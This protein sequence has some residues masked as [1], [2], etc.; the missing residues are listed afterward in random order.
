MSRTT[1]ALAGLIVLGAAAL[2]AWNVPQAA[3]P[4]VLLRAA[5]EKEEVDGNLDAAIEQYKQII[6][7]AGANRAVAAQALLRLGGCYEKRGPEEA[8]RAYEQLIRDYGEQSREV[9][10]A[11]QRLAALAAG[12][13]VRARDSRLAIRRVPDLDMYAKP[14]PDGKFVSSTD[15]KSGNLTIRDAATGATRALTKDGAFGEASRYPEFCAWSRDSRRIACQWTVIG[16]KEVRTELRVV[17]LDPDTPPETIAIPGVRWILPHDWSPDGSRIFCSY[18]QASSRTGFAFVRV[19]DGAIDKLDLPDGG[20]LQYELSR[21]GDAILY[22]AAADGK[23]GPHDIFLRNL[24]TGVT[25]PIIRHPA[26]D[27]LVGVLPGTDWLLFASDRQGR[28]DLWAVPFRRGK[29]DGQPVLV[30]QGLGRFFPLGFTNDGRYHYATLSA[31]DDVFLADFDPATGKVTGDARK[32]PSRWDGVSGGP[33]YSPDGASLA[34]VVKRSPMP[35]PTGVFDTL[36]VQ[37]LSDPKAGPVPIGFEDIGV[38]RV[39]DPCWSADGKAVLVRGYRAQG[40]PSALYRVDVPGLRKTMIYGANERRLIGHDCGTDGAF[41][42]AL[43]NTQASGQKAEPVTQLVRIDLTGGPDR[44]VF[45]APQGQGIGAFAVSPDGKSL[46]VVTSLDR[47]RRALLAMPSE[48]GTPRQILEFRQPTGGGVAHVWAPDGRSIFY[49][50]RSEEQTGTLSFELHSV[51][52]DGSKS[53]PDLVYK[54]TGQFFGLRFHR[55]GR[56]LAFTGRLS[57]STSSEVWV[58]ENLKEELKTL[59]PSGKRP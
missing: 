14:S 47:N 3:D 33:S 34:Y 27:L 1:L 44:L 56:T 9:A 38:T 54:W 32:L 8:R 17:S 43:L 57:Y 20:W 25:T 51:R 19:G 35:I 2:A 48:G 42:F 23:S 53:S 21:E 11:R 49:V 59:A 5:I 55:N 31:T 58:I 12:A 7:I 26:E 28:L 36:V 45:Q 52:V 29:A 10:T 22:C 46:S 6:K 50:V 39:V 40:Q 30:K 13:P 37:S 15:W 18:G 24:K 41:V 4:A 16:S